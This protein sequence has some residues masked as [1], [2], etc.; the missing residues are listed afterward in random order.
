MAIT[1]TSSSS[2]ISANALIAKVEALE[3]GSRAIN[4]RPDLRK[5]ETPGLV[6][7]ATLAAFAKNLQHETESMGVDILVNS[8]GCE[9][10]K[11]LDDL[12]PVD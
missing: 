1:F 2:E 10:V 5:A 11:N 3:N 7:D 6:L 8:A 4:V 9:L 12:T